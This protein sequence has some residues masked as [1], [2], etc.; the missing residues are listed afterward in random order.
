M[1]IRRSQWDQYK[2][3]LLYLEID[4]VE[5]DMVDAF[6]LHTQLFSCSEDEHRDKNLNEILIS[7]LLLFF[8]TSMPCLRV[9]WSTNQSNCR[10]INRLTD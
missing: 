9:I 2:E 5:K 8:K 3:V 7:A 1:K 10:L 6:L 4:I